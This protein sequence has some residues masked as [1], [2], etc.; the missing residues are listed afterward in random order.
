M[1]RRKRVS[2]TP[3]IGASTVAGRMVRFLTLYSTGI[4]SS[5]LTQLSFLG[6]PFRWLVVE[7]VEG[8][9][10]P[11]VLPKRGFPLSLGA[12]NNDQVSEI[13]AATH[14]CRPTTRRRRILL[15]ALREPR[16]FWNRDRPDSETPG[17][18]ES[19]VASASQTRTP[20][21]D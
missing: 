16:P 14:R 9:F 10:A 19:L 6:W 12:G 2:V 4:I 15:Q 21:D 18:H 1:T 11:T 7:A 8:M 3:A 5:T 20:R 17:L 13:F